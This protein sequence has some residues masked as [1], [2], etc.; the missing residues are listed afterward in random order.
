[1]MSFRIRHV[2]LVCTLFA[3]AAFGADPKLNW[4]QNPDGVL[5][6]EDGTKVLFYQRASKSEKGKYTRAHYVHPLYD[7][8]EAILTEDFPSDH[9]HHRGVFWAWH[10][11]RVGSQILGDGWALNDFHW[12]VRELTPKRHDDGSVSIELVVDWKSSAWK[13]GTEPVVVENSSIRIYPSQGDRRQVDFDIQIRA[14]HAETF[15]GGSDDD[16]GYGGFSIRI[17][18][19]DDIRFTSQTGVESPTK[20]AVA[21]SPWMSMTGQLGDSETGESHVSG[22]TILC[23]PGSVG[24]PQPWILR[25]KHSMQNPVWPGQTPV[26]VPSDE[27][28]VLRY[29]LVI[30]RHPVSKETIEGWH[31]DYSGTTLQ[32]TTNN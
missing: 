26:P 24:Y 22:L 8:D 9:R 15:V 3:T 14:T 32:L 25:S 5:I 6:T 28:V 23:N 17:K 16:K 30:H 21:P 12:G 11:M 1:M 29:R 18:L 31:R 10:Q 19:P 27:P 2:F 7:L 4:E 20:L 13:N